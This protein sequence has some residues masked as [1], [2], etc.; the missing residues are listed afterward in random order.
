M[1]IQFK[2][3]AVALITA[4]V[5]SGGMVFGADEVGKKPSDYLTLK[6]SSNPKTGGFVGGE[7]GLI[8]FDWYS[9]SGYTWGIQPD[10]GSKY[11]YFSGTSVENPP[12]LAINII[13]G[14]QWYFYNKPYF[15]LG[16]RA[17]GW[18]GYGH[19]TEEYKNNYEYYYSSVS[20]TFNIGSDLA[21]LW[22]FVNVDKH[23][24]GVHFA[25]IGFNVTV[26]YNAWRLYKGP[27]YDQGDRSSGSNT[28]VYPSYTI[29]LG[30][31]YYYNVNHQIFVDYR[32]FANSFDTKPS[33]IDYHLRHQFTVG[34]AYKF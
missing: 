4:M 24:F 17:K 26:Q 3:L 16:V 9:S 21:F 15:H 1:K 2:K 23:S 29:N 25:P 7:L 19:H 32:Y 12:G 5:V 10:G 34:Y 6:P 14:Y 30:L 13:G 8:G 20:H 18:L 27:G 28:D 11:A 31:H 33:N 22:D